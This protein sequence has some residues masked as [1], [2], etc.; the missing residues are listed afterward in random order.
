MSQTSGSAHE[1]AA[2]SPPVTGKK[3]S[4]VRL[5]VLL[6]ILGIVFAGLMADLF[7]MYDAVEA[8]SQRIDDAAAKKAEQPYSKDEN[9]SNFLTR[10]EVR[11][12][13]GFGPTTSVVENGQL[14]ESYRW[15]GPIPFK[16]RYIEVTYG[17]AEGLAYVGHE[18]AN[19][20]MFGKKEEEK[21]EPTEPASMEGYAAPGPT[22][23]AGPPGGGK[24]GGAPKGKEGGAAPDSDAPAGSDEPSA[25]K[26]EEEKP[27]PATDPD[28]SDESK[29]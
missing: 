4:P 7:Y 2:S 24:G 23:G 27:A 9:T 13:V 29:S 16:R 21:A 15:W 1:S 12:A 17:N 26:S 10:T 5:I 28:S 20:A 11:E 8:A 25:P 19:A 6:V 3:Q 22:M 14:K 18:V